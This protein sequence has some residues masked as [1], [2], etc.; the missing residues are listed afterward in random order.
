MRPG[1][2]WPLAVMPIIPYTTHWIIQGISWNQTWYNTEY[3]FSGQWPT[4]DLF[5]N[6]APRPFD[7]EEIVDSGTAGRPYSLGLT[8]IKLKCSITPIK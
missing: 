3:I 7:V 8:L 1:L 2:N 6:I 4:S 5:L